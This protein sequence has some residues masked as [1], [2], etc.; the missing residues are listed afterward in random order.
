MKKNHS[1]TIGI[2]IFSIIIIIGLI[3]SVLNMGTYLA[4]ILPTTTPA[5]TSTPSPTNTPDP[6]SQESLQILVP[7]FNRNSRAFDDLSVIAQNTPREQLVPVIS[8]LQEIRRAAE[9]HA[10]PSCMSQA[11][12]YQLAYMNTFIDT[13]L[14]LYSSITTKLT[15]ADVKLINQGMG[16]AIQY[17]DQYTIET[18]RLL[19][20][21]LP[22]PTAVQATLTPLITL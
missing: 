9:D 5:D 21:T 10:V 8:Q 15:E 14:K 6:C 17:H 2:I 3:F 4:P 11:K 18:A 7:I 16:L 1:I 12:E 13:L 20:I 22:A 19:G